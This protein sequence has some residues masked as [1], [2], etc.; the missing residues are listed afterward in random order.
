MRRVM[1]RFLLSTLIITAGLFTVATGARAQTGTVVVHIPQDFRAA[2]KAFPAGTY[3]VYQDLLET[4]QTLILRG[5]GASV[6]LLPCTHDGAF[7]G[8]T[9]VKLTRSGDVYY[10]SE[11]VTELGVYTFSVPPAPT[12][13][14]KTNAQNSKAAGGSK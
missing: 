7:A 3:K 11:I 8:G 9:G 12:R 6:L 1:K 13:M 2:G 4:G 10:L 14:A 5:P